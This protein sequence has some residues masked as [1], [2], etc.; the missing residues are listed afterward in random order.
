MKK[1]LLGILLGISLLL[2]G[3]GKKEVQPQ[4]KLKKEYQDEI[5]LLHIHA[6][7]AEFRQ[8]IKDA[9][10]KLQIKINLILPP[11]NPYNRQAK[12]ST[13][14]SSGDSSVDIISVNDE[15]ISEFKHKGYLEPLGSNVMPEHVLNCYPQNY[16]RE[17]SMED[18][19]IYSVPFAMDMMVLWVNDE[20][21]KS[22]GVENVRNQKE[23]EQLLEANYEPGV[24]GYGGSWETTYVYNE[25]SQFI[26]MFGGS[27]GDWSDAGTRQ[28][29]QFLHDM[30]ENGEIPEDVLLDQYEQMEQ[31][32]I[33]GKYAAIFMYS[34]VMK[35][36]AKAGVYNEDKIH[37]IPLPLFSENATNVATWQYVL[38]KASVHKEAAEKFLAYAAGK[39]G[40]IAYAKAMKHLPAR[41]DIIEN[42]DLDIPDMDVWRSYVKELKLKTRPLSSRPMEDI[43]EMGT[44]FQKYVTDEITLDEFCS[45]AQAIQ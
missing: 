25:I 17:I 44:L 20:I 9:E 36:F 31:K 28:A 5:T 14:L 23:F 16:I 1:K 3:C 26:N 2:T 39:E 11:A 22:A 13:I 21:L 12:I 30:I 34:G 43:E 32:F 15:M 42:E 24:Y 37:V 4:Q 40:S 18:G 6:D 41:L 8:F 10:E 27:Y 33:D 45:R 38:N 35:T 7:K 19:Q 29:L